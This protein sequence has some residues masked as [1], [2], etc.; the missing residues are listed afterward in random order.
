VRYDGKVGWVTGSYGSCSGCDAFEGEFDYATH[1]VDEGDE[2]ERYEVQHDPMDEGFYEG[3][4]QC[5]DLKKRLI[6]F[7]K[8]YLDNIMSQE[9]AEKE[10]EANDEWDTE[11]QEMIQFI[12]DHAVKEN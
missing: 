12:K 2:F 1:D 3:C 5:V 10:A 8:S 11:A 4:D 9:E 7:G 6:E